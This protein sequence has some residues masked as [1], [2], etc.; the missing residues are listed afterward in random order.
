MGEEAMR[1]ELPDAS[2]R[3]KEGVALHEIGGGYLTHATH[4]GGRLLAAKFIHPK[5]AIRLSGSG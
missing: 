4:V 2:A 3:K 1:R 5:S